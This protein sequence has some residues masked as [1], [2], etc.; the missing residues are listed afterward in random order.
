MKKGEEIAILSLG[1]PGNFVLDAQK[2]FKKEGLN[3][4]HYDMRFAKPLDEQLLHK[5]FTSFNT[6]ITIEDGCLLGGFGS[7]IIEFM[8]N[9]NYKKTIK[10]LGIPD[11]FINH[12]TQEEL[13]AECNYNSKS[14]IKT[15]HKILKNKLVVQVG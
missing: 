10:R 3:I 7:S 14:I 6:I 13:H 15:V 1:H 9:N 5:I 8:V 12:G 11:K 2:T 4:A